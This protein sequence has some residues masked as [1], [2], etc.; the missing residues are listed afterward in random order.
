[1]LSR[2][3]LLA[4][5][6][7]LCLTVV[8]RLPGSACMLL[9]PALLPRFFLPRN[10]AACAANRGLVSVTLRPLPLF[11]LVLSRLAGWSGHGDTHWR[12]QDALARRWRESTGCGVPIWRPLTPRSTVT[13]SR[14][15]VSA[16]VQGSPF[17]VLSPPAA[18]TSTLRGLVAWSR[19]VRIPACHCCC[20][21]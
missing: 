18:R 17:G 1:M 10:Q 15:L 2:L 8:R 20:R 5:A 19:H 16:Q 4:F 11:A 6:A 12:A 3:A 13:R 7:V 9:H 21:R 14:F